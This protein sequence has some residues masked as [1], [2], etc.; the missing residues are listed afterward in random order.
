MNKSNFYI[1]PVTYHEVSHDIP[2]RLFAREFSKIVGSIYLRNDLAQRPE[3]IIQALLKRCPEGIVRGYAALSLRGYRLLDRPWT[4]II[5][6]AKAKSHIPTQR[7]KILRRDDPPE[8]HQLNGTRVVSDVQALLD[9]FSIQELTG[10]EE[11]IAL[12]D[13]LARQNRQL[14]ELINAEP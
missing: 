1:K 12:I 8:L 11:Q 10:F 5:S 4:P 7:G 6:T 14:I 13:H 2:K 3:F 9:V